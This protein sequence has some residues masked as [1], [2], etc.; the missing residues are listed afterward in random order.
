MI[1]AHPSARTLAEQ[2]Q[3]A[4]SAR[5]LLIAQGQSRGHERTEAGQEL[6]F[7]LQIYRQFA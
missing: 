2:W 1:L 3:V 4:A 7:H 5:L 6:A